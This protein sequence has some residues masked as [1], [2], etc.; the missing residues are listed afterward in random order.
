M[1][2]KLNIECLLI[3]IM[4]FSS[5]GIVSASI[6]S[7][8]S[9]IGTIEINLPYTVESGDISRL[10][11][12]GTTKPIIG[13]NWQDSALSKDLQ[14]YAN[15]FIGPGNDFEEMVTDDGKP[16]LFNVEQLG[17]DIDGNPQYRFRGFIDYSKENG[18]YIIVHGYSDVRYQ[19]ET[20]A[21]YTKD[22]F[23][24]ICKSFIVK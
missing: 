24:S 18:K 20:I 6:Q 9:E 21:T 13:I 10:V 23:A 14:D 8:E 4:M 16:M 17:N 11:M 22:Q 3:A 1:S 2:L 15:G 5:I 12:P 19:G 7:F